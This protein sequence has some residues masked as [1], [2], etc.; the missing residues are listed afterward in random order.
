MGNRLASLAVVAASLSLLAG[1]SQTPWESQ[2]KRGEAAAEP[3]N[4]STPVKL[5]EV[6]WERVQHALSDIQ[7]KL[8]KSDTHVDDW[9]QEEKTRLR[10]ELLRGLQVATPPQNIEVLGRSE[11][12]TTSGIRPGDGS[13]EAFAR[14]LGATTVVYTSTYLGKAEAVRQ[15]AVQSYRTG[16]HYYDR[17]GTHRDSVLSESSIYW[18][19]VA[20]Q[21][22]EH[23][24]IAFFLREK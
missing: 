20:V 2:F 3:L 12:R 14:K 1:C 5:R 9:S 23:G 18:I 7:D 11:F 15:E 13:L 16:S 8:S 4:S 21:A 24:F 22:D 19:P 17:N 6:P 10:G